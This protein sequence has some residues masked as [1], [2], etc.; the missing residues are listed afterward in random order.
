MILTLTAN[1]SIDRSVLL[2]S[3]LE[4]HAVLRSEAE[5]EQAGG[6][7]VNI[8]RAAKAA[9]V[10]TVAVFPAEKDSAF[11]HELESAG[12]ECCAVRPAGSV[13]VNLTITE[14]DGTTT[15]IN[16]PGATV[17]E[18][19]LD[20]LADALLARADDASWLVLA[21]SLPPGAPDGWYADLVRTLRGHR[22]R[23]AVDTSDAPLAALGD[24]LADAA[25]DL[26]KPNA[27]ELEQL[28]GTPVH[29]PVEAA[30]A[31]RI[32]LDKGARTVLAT[33]G[34]RGAV[35]VDSSGA[36]HATPPQTRVVSTVGAGDSSLFGYLLGDLRGAEP[37]DRLRLAVAYGSAAAGLP[38]TTIP[39]PDQ[40]HP[41]L[42]D[43]RRL[44]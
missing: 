6:K 2:S 36:W 17:D 24:R 44:D 30:S 18:A 7:G 37:P 10:G 35:L 43:V 19:V 11:V 3:R 21:G 13:R 4:R 14:P 33:L 40:T 23:V 26:L 29:D 39:T 5:F 9:G 22:A 42:V 31:A 32:L 41:E 27:E 15:K 1:P 12:I 25:P 28:T 8:S 38:G 34:G 16:S 20:R